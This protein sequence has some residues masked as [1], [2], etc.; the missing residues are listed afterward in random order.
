[1]NPQNPKHVAITFD[2]VYENV[3]TYALPI[4]RRFKYPFELFVVGDTIGMGNAFDQ[5]VEPPAKF[6]NFEQLKTMT[7]YGGRLQWHTRSHQDLS[8]LNKEQ[9]SHELMVPNKIREMDREGF[10]WFAYPNGN[11]S[12]PLIENVRQ[13][14]EGAVSCVQGDNIDKYQLNRLTVTDE[15]RFGKST[16]SLIIP[17]YNYGHLAA[18]AIESAIAQTSPPKEI[19]FIDDYSQDR[20]IEVAKRYQDKIKIVKNDKNLGIVGNFNKAVS[21]TSGDYICFLG[22]DN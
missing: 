22:A 6:A 11:L 19:L 14:F 20:S 16:V 7:R 10:R 8:K 3:Y 15:T 1:Y 21:L 13:R 2:G 4:L 17:N 9:L 18:E 12:F 5:H